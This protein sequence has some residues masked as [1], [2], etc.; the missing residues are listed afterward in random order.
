M[1]V[2]AAPGS[3]GGGVK[4]TTF[5][6]LLM[7]VI[8]TYRNRHETV[9]MGRRIE[10]G[11]VYKSMSL[12]AA[13][14]LVVAT[15]TAVIVLEDNGVELVDALVEATSAFATVGIT[16]GATLKLGLLSKI[17][18]IVTMFIGRVGTL[19]LIMALTLKENQRDDKIVRPQGEI[20]VG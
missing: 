1:F 18:V 16:A 17:L 13:G 8:A 6:V 19:S 20:M 14:I 15:L 12:V 5:D 4:I 9:I 11:V 7:T 2:G 10:Q 3:T